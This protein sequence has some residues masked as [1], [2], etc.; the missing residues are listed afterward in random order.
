MGER[1]VEVAYSASCEVEAMI[2]PDETRPWLW[3]FVAVVQGITHT[4]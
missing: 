2:E 4:R 3:C 1:L